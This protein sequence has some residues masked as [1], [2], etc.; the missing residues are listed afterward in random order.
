M[1]ARAPRPTL[2]EQ[3][4][5]PP[6][7]PEVL[8]AL[9]AAYHPDPPRPRPERDMLDAV[10]RIILAQ[11]NTS[12]VAQRQFDTLKAV[13]PRWEAALADGED[14]METVLKRAGGGLARIKAG[15]IH[16]VLSHLETTRGTLHLGDLHDLNDEQARALLQ[17]LPGVGQ[18]TASLLLLFDMLRPAMPVDTNIERWL[19]RLEWVPERW[20]G[21]KV[22]RWFESALNTGL[23]GPTPVPNAVGGNDDPSGAAL[24]ADWATRAALHVA[25]VRHGRQT[26]RPRSPACRTCPLLEWCPSAPIFLAAQENR[27]PD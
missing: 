5:P 2:T 23:P 4:P 18:K 10:I 13:Y 3:C 11:Q 8:S 15:Y 7:L 9:L 22:E 26:C 27:S 14:G 6:E 25:G 20:S 21:E 1:P 17:G 24:P 12:A 16:G 19:K